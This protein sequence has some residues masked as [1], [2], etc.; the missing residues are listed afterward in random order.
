MRVRKTKH[1][2]LASLI[3]ANFAT[4][5]GLKMARDNFSANK[6]IFGHMYLFFLLVLLKPLNIKQK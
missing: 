1:L 3:N 4:S 6:N 5:Y 2:Y